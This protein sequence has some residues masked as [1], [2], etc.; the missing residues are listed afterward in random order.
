MNKE[1]AS[2]KGFPLIDAAS[3][4]FFRHLSNITD[5]SIILIYSGQFIG[6]KKWAT[7]FQPDEAAINQFTKMLL[8][9]LRCNYNFY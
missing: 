1:A 9:I 8:A 6:I 5:N 7:I 4:L 3:L 2:I